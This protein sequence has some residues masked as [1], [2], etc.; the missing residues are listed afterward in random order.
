MGE[1]KLTGRLQAALGTFIGL[2][3]L[4]IIALSA[5]FARAEPH[6]PLY[7]IPFLGT[8]VALSLAFLP[9]LWWRNTAGYIGAIAV[10]IV[11]TVFNG[12]F[13][14]PGAIPASPALPAII[15]TEA[16]AIVLIATTAAAWKEKA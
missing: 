2:I 10:G 8:I 5:G 7:V 9:L 13:A 3:A 1:P 16:L 15:A 11:V 12:I 4:Q 6:P 14:I